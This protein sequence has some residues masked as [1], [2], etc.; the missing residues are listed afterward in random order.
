MYGVNNTLKSAILPVTLAVFLINC[1]QTENGGIENTTAD[2]LFLNNITADSIILAWDPPVEQAD[3]V[4]SY[5]LGYRTTDQTTWTILKSTIPVSD[6]PSIVIHRNELMATDSIFY[7]AARSIALNGLQSD[8]HAST[9]ADADPPGW[10]VRWN[11]SGQ[12][13][14]PL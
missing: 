3:S 9:D 8:F 13:Q 4:A 1:T 10:C 5:E 2:P 14:N 7:F 6:S 11:Y 12:S